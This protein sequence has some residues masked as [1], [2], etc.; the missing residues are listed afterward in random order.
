[1]PA[2]ARVVG[3]L[4]ALGKPFAVILNTKNP[5]IVSEFE[6]KT[7]ALL[8]HFGVQNQAIFELLTGSAEPSGLLPFQMPADMDTVEMQAEDVSGDM[9]C[10]TDSEGH[11][12]DFG[13][14][15]NFSGVIRDERTEKYAKKG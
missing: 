4:K 9:R 14:G 7:T 5:T 12:Y 2:E 8:A 6:A 13:Y 1:M 3:E 15:L 10:H 11:V